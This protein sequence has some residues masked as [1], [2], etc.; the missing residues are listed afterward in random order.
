MIFWIYSEPGN[1]MWEWPGLQAVLFYAPEPPFSQCGPPP[2]TDAEWKLLETR[3]VAHY[4]SE[5][6]KRQQTMV[7]L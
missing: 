3:S 7:L 6:K 1:P 5:L 2:M 4:Y